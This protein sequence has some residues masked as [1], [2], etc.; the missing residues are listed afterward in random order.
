MT[1]EELANDPQFLHRDSFPE[2][3]LGEGES[4]RL[5]RPAWMAKRTTAVL[6]PGPLYSEH[7]VPVLHNILGMDEGEIT[8]AR[9]L[10][11][12]SVLY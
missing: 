8:S 6:E 1:T 10:S 7:T 2:V 12:P 3:V 9:F 4:M 5:P 11:R